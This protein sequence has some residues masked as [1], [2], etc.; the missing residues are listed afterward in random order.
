MSA[1]EN[2]ALHK[3][4][5]HKAQRLPVGSTKRITLV[6]RSLQGIV[7]ALSQNYNPHHC[8]G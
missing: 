3:A 1:A 7:R 4:I 6:S 2:I 5:I 8:V